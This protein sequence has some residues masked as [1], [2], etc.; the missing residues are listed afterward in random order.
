MFV[1]QPTAYFSVDIEKCIAQAADYSSQIR[2]NW[3][4]GVLLVLSEIKNFQTIT[5]TSK[6]PVDLE[7]YKW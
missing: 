3:S 6:L 5:E 2:G 7:W 4:E 1:P